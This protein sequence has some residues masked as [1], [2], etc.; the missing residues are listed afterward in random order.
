MGT[1]FL[2]SANITCKTDPGNWVRASRTLSSEQKQVNHDCVLGTL[3]CLCFR[4]PQKWTHHCIMCWHCL[5]FKGAGEQNHIFWQGPSLCLMNS[6]SRHACAMEGKETKTGIAQSALPPAPTPQD[7]RCLAHA[8]ER[9]AAA[10]PGSSS[11]SFLPKSRLG[12]KKKLYRDF[13]GGPAAK[14]KLSSSNIGGTG[15]IPDWRIKVLCAGSSPPKN[16]YV[17]GDSY[18]TL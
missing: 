18:T 2:A 11:A 7:D 4:N 6:M 12:I 15:S 9:L 5:A 16:L 13:S 3:T 17:C 8:W 1:W 10:T 14:T